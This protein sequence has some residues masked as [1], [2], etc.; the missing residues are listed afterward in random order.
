MTIVSGFELTPEGLYKKVCSICNNPFETAYLSKTT[1]CFECKTEMKKIKG[2]KTMRARRHISKTYKPCIICGWN[3]VT[4][5]HHEGSKT[6]QLC[7]NHTAL[8]THNLHSIQDL[9]GNS[10]KNS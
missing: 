10:S 9:L 6:Y 7:P 4:T 1:C 2:R 5:L 3:K 8:L